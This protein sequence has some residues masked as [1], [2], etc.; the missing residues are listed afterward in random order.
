MAQATCRTSSVAESLRVALTV[1]RARPCA[2]PPE[3]FL[4]RYRQAG[5]YADCY[6]VDLPVRTTQARFIEAFYTTR[7]FKLERTLLAW[8]VKKPSTDAQARQLSQGNVDSFAAWSVERQSGDQ[9]LLC[10]LH[11]RTRSWLMVAHADVAAGACSRLYFGS[12]VVPKASSASGPARL[13]TLFRLLL[14]FHR[15]YS[16]MLLEAAR[17]RL[18]AGAA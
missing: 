2:L 17:A 14:G 6:S 5:G 9:L 7:L 3:S 16:K 11:G 4:L 18:L 1:S 10:D 8:T 12:A 13:G 15:L